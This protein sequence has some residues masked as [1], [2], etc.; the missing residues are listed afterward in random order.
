[1][2]GQQRAEADRANLTGL[3]QHLASCRAQRLLLIS[4]VDVYSERGGVDES[5]TINKVGLHPYGLHRLELE[6]F[7]VQQFS[8]VNV[9]RLPALFCV[10]A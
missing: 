10:S 3:M 9:V 8:T 5:H 7:C 4:T 6:E 1:M 2:E